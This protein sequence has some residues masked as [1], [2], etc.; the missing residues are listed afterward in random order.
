[1][2]QNLI[3]FALDNPGKISALLA[4]IYEVFARVRPT[5][6]NWS[7]IDNAFKILMYLIPNRSKQITTVKKEDGIVKCVDTHVLKMIA[8]FLMISVSGFSQLNGTFKSI[9]SYNAD[10]LTVKTEVQGLQVMYDSAVGALYYNHQHSPGKWRIFYNSGWHDLVGS[11]GS[12]PFTLHNGNGITAVS[13]SANWGGTLWQDVVLDDNTIGSSTISI[14]GNTPIGSLSVNVINS[15]SGVDNFSVS[16]GLSFGDNNSNINPSGLYSLTIGQFVGATGTGAAC[17]GVGVSNKNLL[18]SG[19]TSFNL[20]QNTTAQSAGHGALADNSFIGGGQDENIP[21]N[22]T[23]SAILASNAGKV[24]SAVTYTLHSD[25]LRIKNNSFFGGF[26]TTP[27]A[28]VHI[29][30]GTTTVAPLALTSGSDLT[31]PLAGRFYYNG[32]R[33]GF[34]PS[35]TIKRFGLSNDVAPTN[36]QLMIGNGTDYTVA[37]VTAGSGITVTPGAGTLTIAATG[38]TPASP[39]T[40]VQYNNAGSFG[41][42][43][44]FTW[45]NASHILSV[46]SGSNNSTIS[47]TQFKSD[48]GTGHASYY[49]AGVTTVGNGWLAQTAD[50]FS[51]V[52]TATSSSGSN[53]DVVLNSDAATFKVLDAGSMQSDV[54]SEL[55]VRNKSA[56]S[57]EI[58]LLPAAQQLVFQPS[59]GGTQ[60]TTQIF[61]TVNTGTTG[62]NDIQIL[63][64]GTSGTGRTGNIILTP[65]LSA[66]SGGTGATGWIVLQN[67]PTS[68]PCGTAPSGTLWSNAGV[69]TVC[70]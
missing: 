24:S 51:I 36:G 15:S 1:M 54:T 47:P 16:N 52:L 55:A 63:S 32:T 9:R 48:D 44:N 29:G 28:F 56:T 17:I 60:V 66:S 6:K 40:S 27:T 12:T 23:G 10:S 25:N 35:T 8:L 67:L 46:N 21:A 50:L 34:S 3:N 33:L 57:Q 26:T 64:G 31:S 49:N 39:T 7:L 41:G 61:P 4:A 43:S 53:G 45:D 18:A 37:S 14:G 42:Q 20:S 19:K 59:A 68:T 13:D 58:R 22:S 5:D 62:G 2:I 69:L 70:P 38:G 65:Q 11:G 30:A